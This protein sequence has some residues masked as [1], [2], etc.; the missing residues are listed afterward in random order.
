MINYKFILLS[1]VCLCVSLF[2]IGKN[3]F[4]KRKERDMLWATGSNFFFASIVLLLFALFILY[5]ELK[6]IF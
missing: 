2:F 6:K 5:H 3:K 4:Y 1:F